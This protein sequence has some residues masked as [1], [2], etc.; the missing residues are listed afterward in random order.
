[1]NWLRRGVLFVLSL[2]LLISL[3]GLAFSVSTYLTIA[4][5]NKVE[6]QLASS[7]FYSQFADNAIQQA[8]NNSGGNLGD[9][10][11]D[12]NNPIIKQAAHNALSTQF[13]QQQ[14]N[15]FINSNYAWLEGKQSKPTYTIDLTSALQ[16][17]ATS[18]GQAVT[19]RLAT[20]SACTP[21][22]LAIIQSTAAIDPLSIT[23]RPPSLDPKTTGSDITQE[24]VQ[25]S[26]FL[27][28]PVIS[29]ESISPGNG[30]PYYQK[31][32][33]APLIFQLSLK[34]P[35][36][37]G[38]L[39]L[40]LILLIYLVARPKRRGTRRLSVVL[41]IAGILLLLN[42]LGADALFNKLQKQAFSAS[43][44]SGQ[45]QSIINFAHRIE[46]QLVRI[47]L[48][49]GI[50]FIALGII[51]LILLRLRRPAT[52]TAPVVQPFEPPMVT[53]EAPSPHQPGTPQPGPTIPQQPTA[54]T[55]PP[56]A[57]RKKRP[58]RLIQ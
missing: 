16:A 30:Q 33:K 14:G 57:Q 1:M 43:S 5:P 28:N 27:N 7:G 3:I 19:I 18:V 10:T 17:F 58:P 55:L 52:K 45:Q 23:C 42:K 2:L 25:N 56:T 22:Q 35:Y 12:F 29:P 15:S 47:D 49:F 39:T 41:L 13:L 20:L 31:F 26:A 32:S 9:T 37:W 24:I 8:E 38:A 11:I 36:F 44:N 40:I 50:A 48:Y 54:P 34:A 46:S 4:K 21:A 51:L 53:E 6:A